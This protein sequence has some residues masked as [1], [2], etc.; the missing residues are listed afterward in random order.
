MACTLNLTAQTKRANCPVAGSIKALYIK[1]FSDVK[2]TA[3]GDYTKYEL[4]QDM[5]GTNEEAGGDRNGGSF[6]TQTVDFMLKETSDDRAGDITQFNELLK[7]PYLDVV[8]EYH[9]GTQQHFG[10][11]NGLTMTGGAKT[12]GQSRGEGWINQI[13]LTGEEPQF[14]PIVTLA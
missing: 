5:G 9:N 8:V 6:V 11:Q 1:G 4:N 3:I 12:S 14:S 7:A 13:V 2:S 10:Y